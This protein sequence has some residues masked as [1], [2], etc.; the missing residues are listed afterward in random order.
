MTCHLLYFYS[1]HNALFFMMNC[2]IINDHNA[3]FFDDE[4]F[5]P[6]I[7]SVVVHY[8]NTPQFLTCNEILHSNKK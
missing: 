8:I 1:L 5:I 6:L 4:L 7:C 2:G 3:L